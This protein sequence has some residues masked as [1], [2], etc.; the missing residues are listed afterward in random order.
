MVK[1]HSP[2]DKICIFAALTLYSGEVVE[3]MTLHKEAGH[4]RTHV[5]SNYLKYA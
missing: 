4:I 1:V 5:H 3:V 2:R